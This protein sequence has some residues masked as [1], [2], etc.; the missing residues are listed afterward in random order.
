VGFQ[1]LSIT[2]ILDGG[3]VVRAAL[4]G[5][6]DVRFMKIGRRGDTDAD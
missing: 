1:K 4:Y 5:V 3:A 6:V 2:R